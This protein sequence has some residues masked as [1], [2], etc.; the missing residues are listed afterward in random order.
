MGCLQCFTF[1][2]IQDNML[3]M[4]QGH[5]C[6]R[7]QC[8]GVKIRMR[9]HLCPNGRHC[10]PRRAY[11]HYD[12]QKRQGNSAEVLRKNRQTDNYELWFD[13]SEGSNVEQ[14]DLYLWGEYCN[15][16]NLFH[17]CINWAPRHLIKGMHSTF[18]EQLESSYCI[19]FFFFNSSPTKLS[20]IL[21]VLFPE[22]HILARW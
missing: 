15:S 13:Q 3:A 5:L 12:H 19:L 2:R 10:V 18:F 8:I 9:V 1:S 14:E 21:A 11:T 22:N 7:R 20:K 17:S 6:S 4:L 16:N